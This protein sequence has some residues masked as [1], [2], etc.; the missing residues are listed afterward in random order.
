MILEPTTALRNE[1]SSGCYPAS[2]GRFAVHTS[3]DR[4][5]YDSL[6]AF[7]TEVEKKLRDK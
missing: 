4:E 7:G 3:T 1:V 2:D 6:M 5:L